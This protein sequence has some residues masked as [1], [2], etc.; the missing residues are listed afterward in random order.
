[1]SGYFAG[2]LMDC[3]F[4]KYVPLDKFEDVTDFF[5]GAF[6]IEGELDQ[7]F[8][9]NAEKNVNVQTEKVVLFRVFADRATDD[10]IA[11]SFYEKA[12][13]IHSKFLGNDGP[14]FDDMLMRRA[15]IMSRRSRGIKNGKF[16]FHTP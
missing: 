10:V 11:F 14:D 3:H 7:A 2:N 5:Q 6:D 13:H 9:K 12:L 16:D 4:Q 8:G 1:M 15:N